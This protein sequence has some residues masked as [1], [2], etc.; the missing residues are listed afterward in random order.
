MVPAAQAPFLPEACAAAPRARAQYLCSLELGVPA[1]PGAEQ[2]PSA[3]QTWAWTNTWVCPNIGPEQRGPGGWRTSALGPRG[4]SETQQA[5]SAAGREACAPPI[6]RTEEGK[7]AAFS[8][9]VPSPPSRQWADP[10]GQTPAQ[11]LPAR[12]GQY[13]FPPGPEP[14]AWLQRGHAWQVGEGGAEW[15]GAGGHQGDHFH[16]PPPAQGTV[17]F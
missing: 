12:P 10:L 11:Q 1:C 9:P 13:P 4:P 5:L 8:L 2:P 3:G 15:G 6:S 16:P 7:R 17:P 14:A